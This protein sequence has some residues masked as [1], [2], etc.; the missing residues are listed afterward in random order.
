MTGCQVGAQT[1]PAPELTARQRVVVHLATGL[2]N[3]MQTGTLAEQHT[4]A[5]LMLVADAV[6]HGYERDM[7]AWVRVHASEVTP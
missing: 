1:M 5:L 6:S 7:V 4:A 3:D 2:G